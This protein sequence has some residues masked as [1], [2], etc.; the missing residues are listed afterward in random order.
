MND[1]YLPIGRFA[2]LCRL[3]VKRLR[4][5]DELGLLVPA[6][7]DPDS[8]YRHYRQ[9]AGS[10]GAA[11]RA[12]PLDLSQRAEVAVAAEARDGPDLLPGGVYASAT[13]IGPP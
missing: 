7:V 12:V 5:Y 1:G 11:D 2:R 10:R 13:H 9:G 3:S 6:H 8:G 4:H